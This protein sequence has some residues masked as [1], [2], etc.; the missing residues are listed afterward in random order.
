MKKGL[1]ILAVVLMVG[2]G[3]LQVGIQVASRDISPPDE[4]FF[5]VE[6]LEVAPED[7]AYTY[8]QQ[9]TNE[10]YTPEWLA[11]TFCAGILTS[12]EEAELR[13]IVEGNA[14]CLK[15]IRQGTAC[16]VFQAPPV[17]SYTEDTPNPSPWLPIAKVL[18]CD[19]ELNQLEGRYSEAVSSCLL[20][21]RMGD[22]IQQGSES[23]IYYLVGVA[24]M[25][26]AMEQMRVLAQDEE[27][28]RDDLLRLHAALGQLEPLED[29][30]ERALKQEYR[31]TANTI[32][33]FLS[34][35]D[36]PNWVEELSEDN[37]VK[38]FFMRR[39]VRSRYMYQPNRSKKI[40]ADYYRSQLLNVPLVYA[41]MQLPSDEEMEISKWD[42]VKRNS[43]SRLL[44]GIL[45]P[46]LD[47][48]FSTKCREESLIHATRLVVA[49][50]RFEREKKHW[51]E[52]LQ[53][54]VPEFLEAV[55]MDPFDGEPFRYSA[56]K[57]IVYSVGQNLTD[58]GGSRLVEGSEDETVT[59]QNRRKAEDLVYPICPPKKS[60]E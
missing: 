4:S 41:E 12:L 1:T 56:E 58:E 32:D 26:S 50:N 10:L 45:I 16:A 35:R 20:S 15:W 8:F 14:E 11:E 18:K 21:L 9:A 49:C 34:Q 31:Q 3:L 36:L 19:V 13:D 40:F 23:L 51:P 53:D 2:C 59:P 46:A 33:D 48:V 57:G 54:L 22:L 29:G 27:L 5:I 30:L 38:K 6:R 60:N 52:S 17:M 47:R 37:W 39:P 28:P 24:V 43:I 44:V 55:P 42:Y 7:N 25:E